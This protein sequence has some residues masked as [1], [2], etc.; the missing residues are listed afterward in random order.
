MKKIALVLM[1]AC[2]SLA[3]IPMASFAVRTNYPGKANTTTPVTI[4]SKAFMLRLKEIKNMDK[5]QHVF[6][7]KES[8]AQRTTYHEA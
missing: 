7:R 8:F 1:T 3:F 5:S 4:D 6:F 2:L